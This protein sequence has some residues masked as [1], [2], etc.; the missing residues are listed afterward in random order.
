MK[1]ALRSSLVLFLFVCA[2][3]G[4]AACGGGSAPPFYESTIPSHIYAA[5][6]GG[7]TG[8]PN[9]YL[10]EPATEWN[11]RM[12][13]TYLMEFTNYSGGCDGLRILNGCSI[14]VIMH[15]CATQGS[16]QP[17]FNECAADPFETPY[18]DLSHI[19]VDPGE[20]GV[21]IEANEALSIQ[22]FYCSEEMQLG[23]AT[24]IRCVPL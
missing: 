22:V 24:P 10:P 16:A 5:W 13:A 4:A 6:S 1:I 2:T 9:T 17:N 20:P 14:P 21:C 12:C 18:D 8:E 15:I 19:T 11:G 7:Q 3:L 23:Q